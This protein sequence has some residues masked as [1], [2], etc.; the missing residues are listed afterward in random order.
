MSRRVL[1]AVACLARSRTE[2]ST[3]LDPIPDEAL[4]M[5]HEI[6]QVA[7]RAGTVVLETQLWTRLAR[8][9]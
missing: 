9:G 4:P 8:K 7:D 6:A 3:T 5:S 2:L 1:C